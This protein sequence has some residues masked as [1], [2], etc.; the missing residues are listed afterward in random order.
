MSDAPNAYRRLKPRQRRFVDAYLT[1]SSAT[2]AARKVAPKSRRPDVMASKLL[3]RDEIRAA[4]AER[5]EKLIEMEELRA[6][7]VVRELGRVAYT[8][9][10]ISGSDKVSALKELSGIARLKPDEGIRQTAV[11]PGLTVVVQQVVQVVNEAPAHVATF[12]HGH[13]AVGLA[14]P[15]R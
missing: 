12:D 13:D 3:A 4:V 7:R 1:G 6:E 10:K 9:A 11:G 5:R 2:A 8:R 14:G 15:A